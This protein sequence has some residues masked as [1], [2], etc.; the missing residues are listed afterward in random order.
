VWNF[1]GIGEGDIDFGRVL[2]ILDQGGY[3]GPLTVE[4]EFKGEPWP[5]LAEVNRAM[6][7]SYDKLA[8]LGLS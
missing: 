6:K 3:A 4:I 1:P 2:G 5:S 8:A 7:A